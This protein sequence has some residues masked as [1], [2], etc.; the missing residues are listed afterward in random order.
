MEPRIQD[1][2]VVLVKK[3]DFLPYYTLEK[4]TLED[5][6]ALD[7]DPKTSTALDQ[8]T[9]RQHA[10][11]ID[12]IV[13]KEE[14]KFALWRSPPALSPGDVIAFYS[15]I[16]FGKV[17]VKRLLGLNGQR[18]RPKDSYNRIEH[19]E[20]YSVWLEGDTASNDGET[21]EYS[22][23]VSKKL[24]IGRIERI[25]WPPSRVQNIFAVRPAVGRAWWP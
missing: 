13:G 25:L 24:V 16:V 7:D 2:D 11:R 8:K 3:G 6:R 17:D 22:G 10:L 9:D 15:P 1:G 18:V 19:I 14:N 4:V 12:A 20:P 23:S 21:Q 5:L